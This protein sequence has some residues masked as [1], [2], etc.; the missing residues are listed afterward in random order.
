MKVGLLEG[1]MGRF[2]SGQP[3]SDVPSSQHR[4]LSIKEH[5]AALFNT[6]RGS[7]SHLP[8][9]GLPDI[10]EICDNMPESIGMLRR[11][12][13]ETVREYEP[14][15][16]QVQVV[17]HEEA[18]GNSTAFSVSFNLIAQIV[19]GP[20]AYF[21]AHFSTLSPAQVNTLQRRQ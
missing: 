2:L 19:D 5:L 16:T 1:I 6:R 3:I 11:A 8:D 4:L 17:E 15:L 20:P 13:E 10:S 18:G 12:I 7:L 14:R 21:R 9:Y